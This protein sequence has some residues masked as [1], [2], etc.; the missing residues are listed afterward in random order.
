LAVISALTEKAVA[1]NDFY[2]KQNAENYS[3]N[4]EYTTSDNSQWHKFE[5]Q[6]LRTEKDAFTADFSISD[7]HE[8]VFNQQLNL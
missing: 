2:N 8:N 7:N 6:I 5:T 3:H 4:C 1:V